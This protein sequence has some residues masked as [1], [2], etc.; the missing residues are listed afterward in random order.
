MADDDWL[1]Q[2][3][4]AMRRE[5]APVLDV[6]AR[7]C[8]R[9][10]VSGRP[11]HAVMMHDDRALSWLAMAMALAVALAGVALVPWWDRPNDPW[12]L[13]VDQFVMLME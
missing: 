8:A 6:S 12:V 1:H 4:T 10:P 3:A 5:E 2:L 11:V 9:L 13:V 7:V